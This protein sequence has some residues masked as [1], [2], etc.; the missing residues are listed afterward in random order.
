MIGGEILKLCIQSDEV[1]EV[2]SLV[3]SPGPIKNGK[4][5]EIVHS[6]FENYE[7]IG[8]DL[9]KVDTVYFCM[10][11]YTGMVSREVFR[12]VT[13]D[14]PLALAKKLKLLNP[15]LRFCLLSGA[16][17]DR[18]GKSRM[19]FAL[20][21]G[22]AEN[23]LK[24]LELGS[25]YTFRPAYIYPVVPRKEP[26]LSYKLT[27]R[28]YPLIKLLGTSYSVPSDVLAK[29]M[30]NVG[31]KGYGREIVTNKDLLKLSNE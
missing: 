20:D 13:V 3:R 27:R 9:L 19:M 31:I 23:G 8:D 12:K 21:K 14:Y 1:S 17:A 25:F 11:V 15:E 4:L 28:L 10:G 26:N 2:I 7:D 29:A 16:G 18:T 24:D 6:D 22:M 30:F 5:K